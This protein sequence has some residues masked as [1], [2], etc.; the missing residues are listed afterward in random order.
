MTQFYRTIKSAEKTKDLQN[1]SP[2][3]IRT[4]ALISKPT[5]VYICTFESPL[6]C[7]KYRVCQ[8]GYTDGWEILLSMHLSSM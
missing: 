7:N 8:C 1:Q 2:C 4:T 5:Y 3:T 6:Y